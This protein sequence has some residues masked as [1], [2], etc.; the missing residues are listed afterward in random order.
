MSIAKRLFDKMFGYVRVYL[1]DQKDI[2]RFWQWL[3]WRQK[4][5]NFQFIKYSSIQKWFHSDIQLQNLKSICWLL[6]YLLYSKK[7]L[8]FEFK[9]DPS[10]FWGDPR[11]IR[12]DPGENRGDPWRGISLV[13][14]NL[15]LLPSCRIHMK[16]TYC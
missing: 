8:V 6:K 3:I 4:Y 10:K 5:K 15:N 13:T 9:K 2:F 1:N 16:Y 11:E 14:E 12:E 7:H